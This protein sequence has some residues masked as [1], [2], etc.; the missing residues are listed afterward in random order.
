MYRKHEAR[1]STRSTRA[2]C[3]HIVKCRYLGKISV[4]FA[5]FVETS[6]FVSC[7]RERCLPL[8]SACTRCNE[9]YVVSFSSCPPPNFHLFLFHLPPPLSSRTKQTNKQKTLCGPATCP[10]QARSPASFTTPSKC[11]RRQASSSSRSYPRLLLAPSFF[12][13]LSPPKLSQAWQYALRISSIVW[14][15]NTRG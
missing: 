3:R 12:S 1:D 6:A 14:D 11:S 5:S 15:A 13:L 7:R 4:S 9:G 8:T 2:E 10:W